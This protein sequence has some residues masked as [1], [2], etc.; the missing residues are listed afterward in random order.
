VK[1]SRK[2]PVI[3]I[4]G[5][6]GS[7][8]STAAMEFA[9]LGCKVINADRIAHELLEK[10][11]VYKKVIE[12]FGREVV[13]LAGKIDRKKLADI[14]FGNAELL[15]SLNKLI[16]PLVLTRTQELIEEYERQPEVKAIILDVP[17]LAEVGWEKRCDKLVFVD[18]KAEIRA[19]RA[20][21]SGK[22]LKMREKFQISLDKKARLADNTIDNN[23][24]FSSLAQQ[25]EDVFSHIMDNG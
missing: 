24:G 4:L 23:S 7:G 17:L 10:P 20:K 14:V 12:L 5:G 1:K 8:K 16:H 2:K 6:I 25:V 19:M 18:C 13:D 15:A 22:Q 9:R 21:I 3:G 11:E